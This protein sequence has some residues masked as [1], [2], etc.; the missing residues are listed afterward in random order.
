MSIS[1]ADLRKA[2]TDRAHRVK[3]G[4]N[5]WTPEMWFTAMMG[6][7]GEFANFYK[8][9]VRGDFTLEEIKPELEKELADVMVYLDL[10]A[11]RLDID[12][13]EATRKKFNEVSERWGSDVRL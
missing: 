9:F 13:G 1:F 5:T 7:A 6:E 3:M 8:K 10:L 11:A 12:L 4:L 2:N